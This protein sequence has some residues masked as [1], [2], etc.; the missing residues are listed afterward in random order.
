MAKL[1]RNFSVPS[2]AMKRPNGSEN[3]RRQSWN[4]MVEETETVIKTQG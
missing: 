4:S 1:K 3:V 2:A